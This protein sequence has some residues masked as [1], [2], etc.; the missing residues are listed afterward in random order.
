MSFYDGYNLFRMEAKGRWS[1]MVRV[2]MVDEMA[3]IPVLGLTPIW[4]ERKCCILQKI[5]CPLQKN[6]FK[7]NKTKRSDLKPATK[8]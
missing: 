3:R 2:L 7:L 8:V 6:T 5:N 1:V 4:G